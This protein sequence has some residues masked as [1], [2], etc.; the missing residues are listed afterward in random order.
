MGLM[1]S[2]PYMSLTLS[3]CRKGYLITYEALN[4]ASDV[5]G[6]QGMAVYP[7]AWAHVVLLACVQQC[8]QGVC[9]CV[10][11]YTRSTLAPLSLT[12]PLLS[13][14]MLQLINNQ[15][16]DFPGLFDPPYAG[17]VAGSTD[18]TAGGG[19]STDA[20]SPGSLSP[21][22]VM[23]SSPLEGFLGAPKATPPP[24]SPQQPTP[25]LKMYPSVPAFSPGPG[26]KEEPV[27]LTILQTSTPQPLLG[28]LLPQ[29]FSAPTPPQFR[30]TPVLGY[31][32]PPGGFS[33]GKGMCG[34]R[35]HSRSPGRWLCCGLSRGI[36]RL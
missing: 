18:S 4:I 34:G 14:D 11:P 15:D 13:L 26:I 17:S 20:S 12:Q 7:G 16:S 23:M 31:P 32:S 5:T 24:L 36:C 33:T 8:G 10:M 21:P 28:A 25:T 3:N 27:P 9:N 1:G 30:S 2:W 19:S 35:G 6:I 29:N 22:H